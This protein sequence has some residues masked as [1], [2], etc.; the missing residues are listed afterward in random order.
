MDKA[1]NYLNVTLSSERVVVCTVGKKRVEDDRGADELAQL[2]A[3]KNWSSVGTRS[4]TARAAFC[5]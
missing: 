2:F 3:E 5:S 4:Y 1:V